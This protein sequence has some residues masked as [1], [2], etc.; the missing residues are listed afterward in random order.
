MKR[1]TIA[2][3]LA[4]AAATPARPGP[5]AQQQK[6]ALRSAKLPSNT[7]PR[8]ARLELTLD[9]A[10]TYDNPFN[11]DEIDVWGLFTSPQGQTTRVNGFLDKP[12]TRRL[13]HD[14]EVIEPAGSPV[15]RIRFAPALEGSWRYRVFARDR[16][17]ETSLPGVVCGQSL[18][19]PRLY[20]ARPAQSEDVR[21]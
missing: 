2:L 17:G 14:T 7:V 6:L 12:F 11:P 1:F 3:V 15:W 21:L 19:K 8:Y 20:S 16:S 13:D 9:L 5:F 10:A 18:P 4:L